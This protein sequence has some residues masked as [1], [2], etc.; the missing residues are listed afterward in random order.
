MSRSRL[1]LSDLSVDSFEIPAPSL[2]AAPQGDALANIGGGFC[3]TGCDSTCGIYPTAGGC[4]SGGKT[5]E[6][7]CVPPLSQYPCESV[8]ICEG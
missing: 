5:Y 8:D 1:N 6:Y 7:P 2:S 3:C 4:N